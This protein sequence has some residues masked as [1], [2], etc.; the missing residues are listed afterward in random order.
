MIGCPFP[1]RNEIKRWPQTKRIVRVSSSDATWP[2]LPKNENPIATLA[3][4]DD[5]NASLASVK[6]FRP[7]VAGR[8]HYYCAR[9][10]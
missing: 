2:R 4:P 9:T 7:L 1:D 8:I 3:T 6:N 5:V 10:R